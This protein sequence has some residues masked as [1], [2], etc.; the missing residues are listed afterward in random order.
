MVHLG[1]K[2]YLYGEEEWNQAFFVLKTL[3][4]SRDLPTGIMTCVSPTTTTDDLETQQASVLGSSGGDGDEEEEKIE[5]VSEKKVKYKIIMTQLHQIFDECPDYTL[6]VIGHSLGGAL[7]TLFAFECAATTTSDDDKK[8]TCIPQ[9]VTV[10]TSGA[11]KVGNYD[12]L[13]AFE[14]L[15][16]QGKLRCL[17]VANYR[18][19]ITLCPVRGTF[20]LCH[21]ICCQEMRFRHVGFRLKLTPWSSV[22]SYPPRVHTYCGILLFDLMKMVKAFV[23]MM[24]YIPLCAIFTC[25]FQKFLFRE[26]SQLVYMERFDK[27]KASLEKISLDQLYKDRSTRPWWRIPVFHDAAAHTVG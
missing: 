8:K 26:H 5:E 2:E 16:E 9:P 25:E 19:I 4:K 14:S 23:L 21:A 13:L 6:H 20:A 27:Q 1:F 12:F 24:I 22:I 11:P 10:I 18:D 15:E 17:R 7:A 3:W